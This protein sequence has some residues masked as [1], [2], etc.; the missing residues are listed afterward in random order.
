[1]SGWVAMTGNL[2]LV[3]EL[4]LGLGGG[5]RL[6]LTGS[7]WGWLWLAL[8]AVVIALLVVLYRAE[9]Q[10]ISRRAGLRLLGLRLVAALALVAALFEPVA[11]RTRQE[12]RRGRVIVGVDLS[13]SLNTADPGRTDE[14][15]T[16]LA[17]ALAL[18]PGDAVETLTRREVARRLLGGDWLQRLGADHELELIGFARDAVAGLSPTALAERLA[19]PAPAELADRLVTDWTPVLERGLAESTGPT[20]GVVL[21]SDGRPNRDRAAT[22]PGAATDPLADRLAAR[23]IP[24][25]PVLLGSTEPPRD[26]AIVSL[27][28]PDRVTVGDVADV[29]V[30]LK[31]DGLPP[32]TE[33]PVVLERTG[34]E[35]QR[36]LV[37]VPTDG[38]R[39]TVGFRVPLD[40]AGT[41]TLAVSVGP[42]EGDARSDNDRRT[43]VIEAS[44][45]RA[46]VLLIDGEPR[47]EFQYLRNALVRDPHVQLDAVVFRQ[48]IP[49]ETASP[50]Y[51]TAL[52]PAPGDGPDPLAA[53]DLIV[54]GDV[55]PEDLP[56][57][58][59]RRLAAYTDTRGGTLVLAGGPRGWASLAA[60][61]TVRALLPV[62]EPR[63]LVSEAPTP[64]PAHP[65]LPGGVALGPATEA[66]AEPSSWPMLRF[67]AE[68]ERSQAVWNALP[69]LPWALAGRLK[70]TATALLV[71]QTGETSGATVDTAAASAAAMPFGLGKVLWV[72]TDGTWRWRYRVG[73]AYHHRFWGQVVRWSSAGQLAT[74]NRLVRF[75]PAAPRA[76]EGQPVPLRAQ[77]AEEATLAPGT[78]VVARVFRAGADGTSPEGD[79]VAVVPL[80]PAPERPRRFE[81]QAP[82][83]PAGR[84]VVKLEAPTVEGLPSEAA[85]LELTP[86]ETTERIELAASRDAL[87]RLASPGGGR[88]FREWELAE[89]PPLIAARVRP[90]TRV[91]STSLWDQPLALGLFVALLSLEWIGRKRLGLP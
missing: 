12:T 40:R 61:E 2:R 84:Y 13:E 8:G 79:A 22:S 53:Y 48:P 55:S 34:A 38:G 66:A 23:G 59:W 77:F 80:R 60:D 33:V 44:D 42:I 81:G 17:Q 89:L 68:P 62:T 70:P 25:Y 10:L 35:P 31:L 73:D 5:R 7:A 72:G 57:A 37:K 9:R 45:D 69:R 82:A 90:E 56:A 54:V 67:A 83:L 27:Q 71:P 58:A 6:V 47:W 16:R 43:L 78:L 74:G 64:D 15:R 11:E 3:A 24:V 30:T 91:E 14:E 4:A 29:T 51:R 63:P 32:G 28:A 87:D 46:R 86:L 41:E 52:P 65:S 76:A 20:L 1:M 18:P 39:P 49:P 75:G 21:L 88:V 26:A 19:A 50:T 36:K 85:V